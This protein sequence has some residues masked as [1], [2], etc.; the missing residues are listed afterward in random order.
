MDEFQLLIDQAIHCI[1]ENKLSKA[2]EV[3]KSAFG[4]DVSSP[5]TH[6][7]LG[8]LYENRGDQLLAAKH[9]RAAYALDPS[10]KPAARNLHRIVCCL[11]VPDKDYDLGETTDNED[12]K[13]EYYV[14][15]DADNVGHIHKK[16]H[17]PQPD[18]RQHGK[19]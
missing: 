12:E 1:N 3:L 8:V 19:A 6:N 10:Y 18:V 4:R 9:Y 7:L 14:E 2:E 16:D 17:I 13:N 5:V 11:E 15:Y